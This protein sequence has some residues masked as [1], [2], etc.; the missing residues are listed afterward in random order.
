MIWYVCVCVCEAMVRI[1]AL[2][3]VDFPIIRGIEQNATTTKICRVG[4]VALFDID[5]KVILKARNVI[6][7]HFGIDQRIFTALT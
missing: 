3:L 5:Q 2:A 6:S 7:E 4:G 1:V